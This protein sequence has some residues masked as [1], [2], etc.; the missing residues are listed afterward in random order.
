[1]NKK[2]FLLFEV[3]LASAL[4]VAVVSSLG[5]LAQS[6][7]S[8][9]TL[10]GKK[11]EDMRNADLKLESAMMLLEDDF[12]ETSFPEGVTISSV[13]NFTKRIEVTEGVKTLSAIVTDTRESEGQSSC[14][15]LQDM[16]RWQNPVVTYFDTSSIGISIEPTDIDVVGSYA[17]ITSNVAHASSSDLFILN[18][19]DPT[20]VKLVSE[21][22]TGPGLNALHA[23]GQYV[24]VANS[25]VNAQL[26]IID[27][28]EET[29]PRLVNSYR[30]PGEYGSSTPIGIS[31]FYKK[32]AIIL[33]TDKSDIG[34]LHYID[35]TRPQEPRHVDTEE[36]GHGVNDIFA[37]KQDVYIASPHRDEMKSFT[38]SSSGN[39]TPFSSYNDPGATG[40]GKRV[41][42]F[43][44]SLLLG[45]TKTFN[46]DELLSLVAT[47][48]PT[49]DIRI[50]LGVSVHGVI[51]YGDIIFTILN[52][53]NDGFLIFHKGIRVNLP[54]INFAGAPINFDCDR[55][56]FVVISEKSSILT[57]ITPTS[58][59]ESF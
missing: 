8:F 57:F 4:F 40:N 19:E 32:G 6:V 52:R 18:I 17:Y 36:I 3:L 9:L 43:L 1:M 15:P 5:M 12:E 28:G 16:M 22:D 10:A 54:P 29:L 37:F 24:Y 51:Q 55:D 34:E 2:G 48:S 20:N 14:R 35:V 42:L 26:Q 59:Y 47:S 44:G 56:L 58:S 7:Q 30:I 23:G 33:G 27:V 31:V 38:L 45:K 46:K 21:I 39:M 41:W 11:I 25:S 13:D 50:P 53:T 49:V